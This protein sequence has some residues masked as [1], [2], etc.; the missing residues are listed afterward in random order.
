MI[1]SGEVASDQDEHEQHPSSPSSLAS[2]SSSSSSSCA[3]RAKGVRRRKDAPLRVVLGNESVADTETT[4][5]GKMSMSSQRRKTCEKTYEEDDFTAI[6]LE[7]DDQMMEGGKRV[8]A[9]P[10]AR[11]EAEEDIST[12]PPTPDHISRTKASMGTSPWANPDASLSKSLEHVADVDGQ[13]EGNCPIQEADDGHLARTDSCDI[14]LCHPIST[15]SGFAWDRSS[16]IGWMAAGWCDF[17][18]SVD[19]FGDIRSQHVWRFDD[20]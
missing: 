14:S 4:V 19:A 9:T 18:V 12:A 10:H 17:D 8:L 15:C 2:F 7:S 11:M 5:E 6:S 20:A 16:G 13:V 1:Q 3:F